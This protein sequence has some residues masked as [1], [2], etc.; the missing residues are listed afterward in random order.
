MVICKTHRKNVI[1]LRVNVTLPD[2][3]YF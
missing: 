1:V 2:F 3:C